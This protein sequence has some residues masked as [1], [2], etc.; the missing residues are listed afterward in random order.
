MTAT[1]RVWEADGDRPRLV[2]SMDEDS[3]VFGPVA[4]KLKLSEA[5]RLGLVTP[6]Q[7]LCL[8][9]RDPQLYAAMTPEATGSDVVRGAR[10]AAVQ[11]G[12][13]MM[14]AC[15]IAEH[16]RSSRSPRPC[17]WRPGP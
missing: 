12:W 4:Y 1:A 17:S 3:P 15:Q 8:D 9:I 2:A 7:V 10:L 16:S 5:I 6:Y 13:E 11:T 14:R